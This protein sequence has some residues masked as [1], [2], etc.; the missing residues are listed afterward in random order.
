ML[1][2]LSSGANEKKGGTVKALTP[3]PEGGQHTKSPAQPAR[4]PG[5]CMQKDQ[6]YLCYFHAA[7]VCRNLHDGHVG[8]LHLL[9]VHRAPSSAARAARDELLL[10]TGTL[11][12]HFWATIRQS[13][14]VLVLGRR[15]AGCWWSSHSIGTRRRT[16][17]SSGAPCLSTCDTGRKG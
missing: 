12:A 7:H 15:D 4:K 17:R 1:D 5:R 8:H 16:A 6:Y 13:S 14:L 9:R 11:G 2:W 3:A 10:R